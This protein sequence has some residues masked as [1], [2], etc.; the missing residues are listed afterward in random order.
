MRTGL[1]IAGLPLTDDY[2]MALETNGRGFIGFV[3]ELPGAFVRGR[4]ESEILSKVGIEAKSYLNWLGIQQASLGR[5]HVVQR[6]FCQLT[7][8]DADSEI[9]LTADKN[10]MNGEEFDRLAE[11]VLLSGKTFTSL[12]NQCQL[13]NWVDAARIRRTF[14]GENPASIQAI[15]NHVDSTQ[16]YYLSRVGLDVAQGQSF[17]D[18]RGLSLEKIG[19]LH[20]RKNNSLVYRVEGESW[21][22]KKVLRRLVWHDRIHGKAITRILAKQKGLGLIR[23]YE[24][25]FHLGL[26]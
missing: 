24:D 9:L 18:T 13:K 11:I 20:R 5:G 17:L 26:V 1:T 8:E 21:T 14:Y 2:S 16:R 4:S 6:H 25:S 12:Y 10:P 7:V 3:V 19:E 15:F 23:E 22:V